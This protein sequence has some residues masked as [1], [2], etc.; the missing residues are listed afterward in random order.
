LTLLMLDADHFKTIN[1]RF[2][3]PAGDAVLCSLAAALTSTFRECDIVARVGGEEFAVLLPSTSVQGALAVATRLLSVVAGQ[4]LEIEGHRIQYTVSGGVASMEAD[5][6][7][8]DAL[9][10]RADRALYAAKSA[11][12]NRVQSFG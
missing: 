10:K 3:H 4:T 2:G 1:D 8:F 7:G 9:M 12:R 5:V 6:T 11:G